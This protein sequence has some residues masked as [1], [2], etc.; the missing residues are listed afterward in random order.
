MTQLGMVITTKPGF[1]SRKDIQPTGLPGYGCAYATY[2]LGTEAWSGT[3]FGPTE[4]AT[5]NG[6]NLVVTGTVGAKWVAGPTNYVTTPF[7]GDQLCSRTGKCTIIAVTRIAPGVSAW[8]ISNHTTSGSPNYVG[9]FATNNSFAYSARHHISGQERQSNDSTNASTRSGFE[10]IGGTFGVDEGTKL[11]RS[12][13]G[14]DLHVRP[15]DVLPPLTPVG[16]S[17]PFLIGRSHTLGTNGNCDVAFASFFDDVL[18]PAQIEEYLTYVTALLSTS[19]GVTVE[20]GSPDISTASGT[21]EQM[22]IAAVAYAA[23]LLQ[24]LDATARL[25]DADGNATRAANSADLA[26]AWAEGSNPP[27]G[28]G[29]QSAKDWAYQAEAAAALV[30]AEGWE[31]FDSTALGL[32]GTSEGDTFE[33]RTG[34]VTSLYRHDPGNVATFIRTVISGEALEESQRIG[35]GASLV[36]AFGGRTVEDAIRAEPYP[37]SFPP[38]LVA[39]FPLT[40]EYTDATGTYSSHGL[41]TWK[42]DL[43]E[44]TVQFNTTNPGPLGP[45]MVFGGETNPTSFV[46]GATGGDLSFATI[47]DAIGALDLSEFGDQFTISGWFYVTGNVDWSSF[48]FGSHLEGGATEARQYGMYDNI[49]YFDSGRFRLSPHLGSQDGATPGGIFN[50]DF[51]NGARKHRDRWVFAVATFDGKKLTAYLDGLA[52]RYRHYSDYPPSFHNDPRITLNRVDID[53]NPYYPIYGRGGINRSTRTKIF[54]IG[55]AVHASSPLTMINRASGLGQGFAVFNRALTPDEI[56]SMHMSALKNMP[57]P[58]LITPFDFLAYDKIF[59]T[60]QN[61]QM[62][63]GY[64]GWDGWGGAN[65]QD[66]SFIANPEGFFIHVPN[67][68]TLGRQGHLRRVSGDPNPALTFFPVDGLRTPQVARATWQM[69]SNSAADP[70]RFC[71]KVDGQWYASNS[72]FTSATNWPSTDNVWLTSG[73]VVSADQLSLTLSNLAGNWRTLT[74]NPSA[75]TATVTSRNLIKQPGPDTSVAFDTWMHESANGSAATVTAISGEN[76][77]VEMTYTTA[78]TTPGGGITIGRGPSFIPGTDAAFDVVEGARY[79]V[80]MQ[81][82]TVGVYD[83]RM[84]LSIIYYTAAGVVVGSQINGYVTTLKRDLWADFFIPPHTA[85]VGA[86]RAII[87]LVFVGSSAPV[88]VGAKFRFRRAYLDTRPRYIAGGMTGATWSGT[89]NN[90]ATNYSATETTGTLTL[91]GTANTATIPAGDLEAVGFYSPSG[92]GDTRIKNLELWEK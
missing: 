67:G 55:A 84:V 10:F 57:R 68:D 25:V 53:K 40:Q 8:P 82:R 85:P 31:F 12:A 50:V 69:K 16:G 79:Y 19:Q 34:G 37:I 1:F 88:V 89:P 81:A 58:Y 43:V 61:Y 5:M 28:T 76:E 23:P 91:G 39:F 9:I 11:Y 44:G 83:N 3:D 15:A 90:S 77:G 52:D 36:G 80:G 6:R 51:A 24:K 45:A 71:I 13:T 54:S 29:T 22:Q 17:L 21:P 49:F 72:T 48:W 41:E 27:G 74:F 2:L 33:V 30:E 60:V 4:D 47:G 75:G 64:L 73:G 63:V 66:Q 70:V 78:P 14:D 65:V 86:K 20:G 59:G 87:R 56:M 42:A 92:V 62:T 18:T 32:A 46:V 35:S 38:G 7:N 26:Q